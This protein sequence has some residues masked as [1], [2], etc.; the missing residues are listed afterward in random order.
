MNDAAR[1][2]RAG[3]PVSSA[4]DEARQALLDAGFSRVDYLALVDAKTLDPLDSAAGE[5]RLIAA[6]VI[7]ST[8]L[9]DNLPV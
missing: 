2:I 7:G 5:M 1:A 8:R 6:A 4:L 3:Q 9:I